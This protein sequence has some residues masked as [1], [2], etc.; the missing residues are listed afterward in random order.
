[1]TET[2]KIARPHY[3]AFDHWT[4]RDWTVIA[5]LA[6]IL[7]PLFG[8]ALYLH[9]LHPPFLASNEVNDAS[10]LNRTT[11]SKVVSPTN[12]EE[13]RAAI[14]SARNGGLK[15]AIAGARH[16]MG[17][18]SLYPNA[19]ALDMRHYN[20]L[21]SI[22]AERKLVT[23]ES[24][25]TWRELQE[26]L[27]LNGLAVTVMQGPNVFTVGGS[28][29]VNAHGWDM[30]NGPTAATV[31][32]FHIMTADGSVRLCSRTANPELFRL[33]LGGYGLFGVILDVTLRVTTNGAYQATVSEMDYRDFPEY[34]KNSILANPRVDL[35][36]ADLSI[37]PDT[38]LRDLVGVAY[39]HTNE[40]AGRTDPLDPEAHISRDRFYFDLSRRFDWGKSLRWRLQKRY[41]YPAPD[42]IRTRNNIFRS[43]L[44]R[45]QHYSPNDADILQEYFVPPENLTGFLDELRAI[46]ERR[47]VNL[48]SA[49]IRYVT[50][51]D[52]AFLSYARR[53]L[54]CVVIYIN[55]KTSERGQARAADLTRELID[56]SISDGGTFY[57]PYVLYYDK[58]ELTAAY[59][60]IDE[61]FEMKRQYDPSELF[62]NSFYAK[63]GGR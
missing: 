17:G 23:V 52:D 42:S 22:D 59:P 14:A 61:F 7:L 58:S 40:I 36:E 10:G 9:Y 29:S 44:E 20:R 50:A 49:T 53:D 12:E 46:I 15:V 1:M 51:N 18:Q 38:L 56:L 62:M 43:P 31:E 48:L 2:K 3:G 28:I 41:E 32:S 24:G 27:N 21:V 37:S 34:F 35:A 26:Y 16:S 11:V 47:N 55:V 13:I 4:R 57:L 8:F 25:M 39:A 45:I 19:I 33:A 5:V 30:R 60:K 54:F 63:Y 6:A